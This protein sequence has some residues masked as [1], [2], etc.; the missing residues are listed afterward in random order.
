MFVE[1][2]KTYWFK[3]AYVCIYTTAEKLQEKPLKMHSLRYLLWDSLQKFANV[4]VGGLGKWGGYLFNINT[5][6]QRR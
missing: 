2:A 6:E 4:W 1:T 5:K 3:Y